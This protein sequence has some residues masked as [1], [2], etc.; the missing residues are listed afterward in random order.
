MKARAGSRLGEGRPPGRQEPPYLAWGQQVA[1]E[2]WPEPL[3]TSWASGPVD[4]GEALRGQRCGVSPPAFSP[5]PVPSSP[6]HPPPTIPIHVV[7]SWV[8][9]D[10]DHIVLVLVLVQ[11]WG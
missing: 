9:S 4:W 8:I 5:S 1:L 7:G 3:P 2:A 6:P 10:G 11:E